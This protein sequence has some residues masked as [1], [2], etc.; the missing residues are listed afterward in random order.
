ML[1]IYSRKQQDDGT[2]KQREDCNIFSTSGKVREIKKGKNVIKRNSVCG[3]NTI[4][5]S[6]LK[7][8]QF[9]CLVLL[10][11]RI[12]LLLCKRFS[13]L[14]LWIEKI[15]FTFFFHLFC[16]QMT[17][18]KLP[19]T[20]LETTERKTRVYSKVLHNTRFLFAS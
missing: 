14:Y 9:C 7:A 16:L 3:C 12:I 19:K 17:K 11:L 2:N 4:W 1:K 6:I 8:T 10:S 13:L 5:S 18:H 20:I 15:F